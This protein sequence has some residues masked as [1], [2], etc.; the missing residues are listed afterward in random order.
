MGIQQGSHESGSRPGHPSNENQ[1]H[2]S[3]VL[4]GPMIGTDDVLFR[5]DHGGRSEI[6]G[7]T[8]QS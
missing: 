6:L 2:L 5:G 8:E 3:V 7:E 1:W 4:V